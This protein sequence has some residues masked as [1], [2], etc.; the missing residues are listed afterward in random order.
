MK[1]IVIALFTLLA[2]GSVTLTSEPKAE[3]Q[4]PVGRAC[5]DANGYTRCILPD[6]W[7]LGS[8]C[9]CYGQGYGLVCR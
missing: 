7:T 6:F 1:K 8:A 9:F 2:I 3:A 4:V 5:C